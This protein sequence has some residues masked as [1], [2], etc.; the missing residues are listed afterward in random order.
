MFPRNGER[1][2]KEVLQ[3][4]FPPPP[5]PTQVRTPIG[6]WCID[7]SAVIFLVGNSSWIKTQKAWHFFSGG[8]LTLDLQFDRFTDPRWRQVGR[9]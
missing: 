4:P 8:A 9:N 6:E 3:A 5:H 7:I 1:R 2:K